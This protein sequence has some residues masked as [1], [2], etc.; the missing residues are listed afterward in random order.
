MQIPEWF[1]SVLSK[2]FF[3]QTVSSTQNLQLETKIAD[4][5]QL[6]LLKSMDKMPRRIEPNLHNSI[7]LSVKT[8][9]F[10]KSIPMELLVIDKGIR[11]TR[12]FQSLVLYSPCVSPSFL[13]PFVGNEFSL[14]PQRFAQGIV[15]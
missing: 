14:F 10:P 7:S 8:G 11:A 9:Y 13:L 12:C 1:V 3:F 4:I 2:I 5:N 15:D 6:I